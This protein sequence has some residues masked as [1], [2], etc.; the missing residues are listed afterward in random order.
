MR[1]DFG[2]SVAEPGSQIV[3]QYL[4]TPLS[5]FLSPLRN[6]LLFCSYTEKAKPTKLLAVG[7]DLLLELDDLVLEV[8][9]LRERLGKRLERG[10]SIV[11][12][13]VR[14]AQLDIADPFLDRG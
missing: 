8:P 13:K 4:G 10:L 2:S 6:L 3:C 5:K 14:H 9:L 7:D 11:C 12:G 1:S